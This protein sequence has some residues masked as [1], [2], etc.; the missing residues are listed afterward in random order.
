MLL[1]SKNLEVRKKVLP[2]DWAEKSDGL[3]L[4][5]IFRLKEYQQKGI[6]F[7]NS[8]SMLEKDLEDFE[9]QKVAHE[10]FLERVSSSID[11]TQ[12]GDWNNAVRELRLR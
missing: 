3:N 5:Q 9:I 2:L 11:G 6:S 10:I 8:M 12:E 4:D 1:I 7:E